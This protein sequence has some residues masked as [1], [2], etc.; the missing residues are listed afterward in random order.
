LTILT[1]QFDIVGYT[2]YKRLLAVFQRSVRRYMPDVK[3]ETI[4]LSSEYRT[5]D[6]RYG[7]WANTKK[8]RVWADYIEKAE[9]N[10]ILADCDMLM[11]KSAEH[12]FDKQ[13]DIAYTRKAKGGKAPFNNGIIMVRPTRA[14]KDFLW[15]WVEINE[16][17]FIDGA[18]HAEWNKR[19]KGMN[20][21][22]FGY[23]LETGE[24]DAELHAY[25][26][27]EWNAVDCNWGEIDDSTVFVHVKG[28]LRQHVLH[29]K[30]PIG[31]ALY[32]AALWY[33]EAGMGFPG[34]YKRLVN[35]S[36]RRGSI[37]TRKRVK[38]AENVLERVEALMRSDGAVIL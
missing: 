17:M 5:D 28:S 21:T 22:A 20:Q 19:Y 38:R 27:K 15:R 37:I 14:A 29:G 24:H 9:D 7:K 33:K 1:V 18:F 35:D 13:F 23:L 36:H 32:P 31:A 2:D 12:A 10:V 3:F 6:M 25:D 11:I 34:Q 26:T 16:R 4:V 8:L 30:A